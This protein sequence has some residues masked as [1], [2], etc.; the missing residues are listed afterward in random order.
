MSRLQ[1]VTWPNPIL[2][3]PADPVTN[4]N[5]DL[6]QLVDNMFVAAELQPW[7]V[8]NGRPDSQF[9]PSH[10]ASQGFFLLRARTQMREVTNVL[11]K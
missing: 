8:V 10:L 11:L 5:G 4:F 1:I 3:T 2:E 9:W 7:W 6:K